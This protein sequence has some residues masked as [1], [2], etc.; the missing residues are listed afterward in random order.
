MKKTSSFWFNFQILFNIQ[1]KLF[2]LVHFMGTSALFGIF[3][4]SYI[5]TSHLRDYCKCCGLVIMVRVLIVLRLTFQ[6]N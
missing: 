2:S 3:S 4:T 5:C 6:S 1:N